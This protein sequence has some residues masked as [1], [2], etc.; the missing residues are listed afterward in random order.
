MPGR[1]VAVHVRARVAHR[2]QQGDP[3]A[4]LDIAPLVEL[5]PGDPRE[6]AAAPLAEQVE[7]FDDPEGQE[8]G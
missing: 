8:E 7:P 6:L 5:S 2:A 3:R 4:Q 1:L